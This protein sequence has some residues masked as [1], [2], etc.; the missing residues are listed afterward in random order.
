MAQFNEKAQCFIDQYNGFSVEGPDGKSHPI[1]GKVNILFK[2]KS[3]EKW[4]EGLT[5]LVVHHR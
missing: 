4:S 3:M 2:I 5:L 1:N